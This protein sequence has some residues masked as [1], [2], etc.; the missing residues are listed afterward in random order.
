MST[1]PVLIS[2]VERLLAELHPAEAR[3][4]AAE[5]GFAAAV[6]DALV[7]TGLSGIGVPETAGG[8]GGTLA[9]AVA[10][11]SMLASAAV[12]VPFAETALV[13]A[14]LLAATPAERIR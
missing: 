3:H 12:P 8:S 5:A 14:P 9:D 2:T 6:W 4:G 10:V 1:D 13:G 7:G 11:A